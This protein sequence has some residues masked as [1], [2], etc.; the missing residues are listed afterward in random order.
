MD[1][2]LDTRAV[3]TTIALAL[4]LPDAVTRRRATQA[5]LLVA[6]AVIVVHVGV[7]G[8]DRPV[9]WDE[10][11]HL[12]QVNPQR[13]AVFMEPHR[14]RGLSLLVAPIA[15]FDPSMV[16]LR[17]GLTLLGAAGLFAAFRT[18]VPVVGWA[19]PVAAALY[20]THWVTIFYSVEVLP[21]HPAALLSVAAA[22][23]VAQTVDRDG[24]GRATGGKLALLFA[25]FAM[26]RPPDA[27]VVGVAVAIVLLTLQG[28]RGVRPVVLAA[29]GG[30]AGLLPW[31][32]EG[33]VRFGLGPLGTVRSAS[34][35]SVGGPSVNKLPLYL[36]SLEHKLRCARSCLENY[37]ERGGG[38]ELP[39]PATTTVLLVALAVALV[40]LVLGGDRVRRAVAVPVLA[41][42]GLVALYGLGGGAMNLRYLM[43][44][45]ALLLFP[46]AIG[47]LVV[48]S[49]LSRRPGRGASVL[50]AGTV[51]LLVLTSAWQLTLALQRFDGPASR[52]RAAEL[53]MALDAVVDGDDCAVASDVNYP[54]IQYWSGCLATAGSAAPD[55]LQPPL[56]D[57]GS[58]V[59]LDAA[60]RRGDRLFAIAAQ[61][62]S[63]G[64]ILRMWEVVTP[65]GEPIHGRHIYEHVAG[66]P[67][68]APPCP[69]T[70]APG[71]TLA[72]H[73]SSD[74]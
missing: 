34:E 19:A 41:S 48:W 21:N 38:W 5:L 72:R 61:D 31:L 45:Y 71:F 14:T 57:L 35:Y 54:Q 3:G 29:V 43:P 32:V 1:R 12:S 66:A 23:L 67:L 50:R 27:A 63:E 52:D 30:A 16:A 4:A 26:V 46:P 8:L 36:R 47:G 15:V 65:G 39:P 42:V 33:A 17:A 44:A 18:W 55:T 40:G 69:D 37:A 11:I 7:V 28:R 68:P 74:C 2:T 13:P 64:D 10:V 9:N 58:Y 49:S 25:I 24:L 70:D 53:G 59:D 51:V 6:L 62:L 20:A 22:G 56:G 60:A 73:L